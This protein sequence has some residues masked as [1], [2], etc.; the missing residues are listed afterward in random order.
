[1]AFPECYS[2]DDEECSNCEKFKLLEGG[3]PFET[4]A[5]FRRST[6]RALSELRPELGELLG[7]PPARKRK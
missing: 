3:E 1:M 6:L 4:E 2:P 7:V 5:E